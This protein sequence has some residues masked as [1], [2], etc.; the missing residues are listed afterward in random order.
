LRD[1]RTRQLGAVYGQRVA[2]ANLE[3]A[4]GT[5]NGDSDVLK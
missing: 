1:A 5:L 4:A 3:L 2:A